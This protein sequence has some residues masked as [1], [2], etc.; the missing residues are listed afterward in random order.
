[1][2]KNEALTKLASMPWT[3]V[4]QKAGTLEMIS[5]P[6]AFWELWR[7]NKE[8]LK[9]AK[10]ECKKIDEVWRIRWSFPLPADDQ[11]LKD[12]IE[13]LSDKKTLDAFKALDDTTTASIPDAFGAKPI[14]VLSA[15]IVIPPEVMEQ[16]KPSQVPAVAHECEII[17][18]VG[19]ALNA[20]GT[21]C[22][23]TYMTAG[24]A[25][26]LN[27]KAFVIG[28]KN[29]LPK[30]RLV[31]GMFKVDVL[32][33]GNYDLARLGKV[34][35]RKASKRA[36]TGFVTTHEPSP[37]LTVGEKDKTAGTR[38][39]WHLPEDALL[40]FD[41]AHKMKNLK[42]INSELLIAATNQGVRTEML[43]AT[44]GESPLKL[45][46]ICH[47]LGLYP[48]IK[49]FYKWA[50][51][52]GCNYVLV[53]TRSRDIN[54]YDFIGNKADLA[55]LHEELFPA[56]GVRL[57]PEDIPEFPETLIMTEVVDM[58]ANAAKIQMAYEKMEAELV[59]LAMSKSAGAAKAGEP[60]SI[61]QHARQEIEIL[62]VPTLVEMAQDLVDSGNSV[63]IF[64][65]FDAS[66]IALRRELK[67]NCVIW[68][69][70][71]AEE[72]ETNRQAFQDDKERIIV[73]NLASGGQSIDLHDTHGDYP[74]V[75]LITPS[76]SAQDVKQAL[77]R[78]QRLGGVTKSVQ[79]II[80]CADT[81]EET[82][83]EN[84]QR[85]IE[86]IDALNDGDLSLL[87]PP[88]KVDDTP[89]VEVEP[90]ETE[91]VEE[92]KQITRQP[93]RPD[94]DDGMYF[95]DG[96]IYKVQHAIYGSGR[97][98]AKILTVGDKDTFLDLDDLADAKVKC[99]AKPKFVYSQ[100]SI[101]SLTKEDKMKIEQ[102]KKFG[103]IYGCCCV[104]G[105]ALTDENSIEAGIGPI[106]A[107]K[108]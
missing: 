102:A 89:A 94:V 108:F 64:V 82:V 35:H 41:E 21:G 100:G 38:F 34:P 69:K 59:K 42:S 37:Y 20:S 103:E 32:S 9:A 8:T 56:H 11:K 67:T 71:S 33:V 87:P 17:A 96:H 12:I 106:C 70:Q 36:K 93:A 48:R 99:Y 55:A 18:T 2:D 91:I 90:T 47:N 84:V 97:P 7:E 26:T 101:S 49:D 43:S 40:I 76:D 63:V 86:N 1:M 3:L 62:K 107:N 27:L 39:T 53:H 50:L 44:I 88:P 77:G 19:H 83:A 85:K 57:K 45:A 75:S 80:F 54:T 30:W 16:L 58:E 74:R 22:G 13:L 61:R 28:P 95:K 60:L 81:I 72:R 98:Y 79:K 14:P 23:K 65:N 104:C 51:Q 52:Y 10:V 46:A 105:R 78:V 73:C 29:S 25:K 5:P 4:N 24:V 68:G 66:V 6:Q 31:L 92:V 15:P